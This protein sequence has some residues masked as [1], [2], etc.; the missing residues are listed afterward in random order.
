MKKE[1]YTADGKHPDDEIYR[2]GEFIKELTKV[3]DTYFQKL[4]TDLRLNKKGED[5]L[6]DYIYNC[7]ELN[8]ISFEE[9]LDRYKVKYDDLVKSTEELA[10]EIIQELRS[11]GEDEGLEIVE[12]IS[13]MDKISKELHEKG[14]YDDQP[15]DIVLKTPEEWCKIYKIR[16][17]DPDGWRQEN[18]EWEDKINEET[19]NRLARVSTCTLPSVFSKH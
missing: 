2:V 9:Y 12:G 18:I 11:W 14:L 17:I 15:D 5:W 3:K 8:V 16:V 19:F 13:C 7:D 6:F 1:H 10:K 4:V